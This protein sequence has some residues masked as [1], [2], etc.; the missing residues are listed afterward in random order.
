M[1]N[2]EER[3]SNQVEMTPKLSSSCLLYSSL[4]LVFVLLFLIILFVFPS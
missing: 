4:L 1:L 2:D 3:N